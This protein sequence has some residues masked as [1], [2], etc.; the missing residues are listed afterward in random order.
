MP[1][2]LQLRALLG[3][4]QP[5]EGRFEKLKLAGPKL[6]W[7]QSYYASDDLED[8]RTRAKRERSLSSKVLGFCIKHLAIFAAFWVV[9]AAIFFS[10]SVAADGSFPS[11][12]P[13]FVEPAES[14]EDVTSTIEL[15]LMLTVLSLAPS[16]LIMTTAFTRILVVLGFVRMALSTQQLPPSQVLTGMALILTF[17]IMRPTFNDIRENALV[18]Y[19]DA[20]ITQAEAF[21]RS[22]TSMRG[23]MFSQVARKDLLM[24]GELSGQDTSE[25]KTYGDIDSFTLV[26]AFVTSELKRGFFM[27]LMLYLPFLV[28]DL[29]VATVLISMGMLVLPPVLISLPFKLMLFVL[30]DGWSLVVRA[31][32]SSFNPVSPEAGV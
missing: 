15:L 21:D 9:L 31:L 30:V 1:V 23:F 11:I 32:F 19:L 14:P 13:T 3:T 24:F 26:P 4:C 18:P 25:W 28:I 16:I 7:G 5:G 27:G 6:M 12:K 17:L 29:I 20:E 10:G 2:V 22:L 8:E